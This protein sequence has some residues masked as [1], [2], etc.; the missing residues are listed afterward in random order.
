MASIS[1]RSAVTTGN[2]PMGSSS[3]QRADTISAVLVNVRKAQRRV[4]NL[5][6]DAV[7]SIVSQLLDSQARPSASESATEKFHIADLARLAGTTTRNVRLYRERGLL[8]AP[9]RDGRSAIYDDSHLARLRLIVSMLDRGY[10]IAHVKEM[11]DAWERGGNIADILGVESALV[12]GQW[13]VERP[14]TVPR[15]VAVEFA[16]GAV[17]LDE[18]ARLGLV[19][20]EDSSVNLLRPK[21]I[22]AFNEA[23]GLGID[24]PEI[25]D[26]HARISE[27]LQQ[28]SEILVRAG[29]DHYLARIDIK[30]LATG[31]A[32]FSG[33][34]YTLTR[35]RTLATEAVGTSMATAIDDSIRSVLSGY[36]AALLETP[37]LPESGP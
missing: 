19:Q 12:G 33:L 4:R 3:R 30:T 11:I 10:K 35:F 21:L 6:R 22:N 2:Q 23:R 1:D 24:M 8:H 15:S 32:D 20:I 29:A 34:S 31:E 14:E 26:V 37:D 17:N 18:M 13:A 16:G 25:L 9:R 5:S 27:L 28:V 36:L 7:D